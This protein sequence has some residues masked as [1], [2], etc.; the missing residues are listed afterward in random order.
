MS[1]Y[2]CASYTV[3]I[4][5]QSFDGSGCGARQAGARVRGW[6]PFGVRVDVLD[7]APAEPPVQPSPSPWNVAP[8]NTESD[9]EGNEGV[10]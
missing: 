4:G 10:N 5:N 2:G 7:R 3:S 6:A 9:H 1:R 8:A